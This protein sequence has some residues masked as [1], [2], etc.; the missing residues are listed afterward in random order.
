MEASKPQNSLPQSRSSHF[1]GRVLDGTLTN[2]AKKNIFHVLQI[3]GI[4]LFITA[5]LY[6]FWNPRFSKKR[7]TMRYLFAITTILYV[8]SLPFKIKK[9]WK[10]Q[11]EIITDLQSEVKILNFKIDQQNEL[12]LKEISRLQKLVNDRAAPEKAKKELIPF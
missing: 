11:A 4:I 1:I 8:V 3:I 6:S 2:E 12:F 7:E 5:G 10:K 9:Y